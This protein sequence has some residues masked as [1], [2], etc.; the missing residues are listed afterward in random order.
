MDARP[1]APLRAR[2]LAVVTSEN[3]V[4]SLPAALF[5]AVAWALAW[6]EGG[7]VDA[8]DWLPYAIF[9]ALLLVAVF[10]SGR[11]VR[12]TRAGLIGV[13]GLLCLAGWTAISLTWSPLPEAAR[14]DALLATLYAL[15]F[16]AALVVGGQGR[17]KATMLGVVVAGFGT[18]ALATE[19][20]L[21]GTAHPADLYASG[22]LF[23][24]I[25]YWNAQAAMFL[26]GFWPAVALAARRSAPLVLRALSCGVAAS[27]LA[28]AVLVQSKGGTIG[29]AISVIAVLALAKDRLRILVVLLLTAV[30]VAAAY[31]P[32][33]RPYR[34][35]T[36]GATDTAL[37]AGIRSAATWAIAIGVG[38]AALGAIYALLDSRLELTA[39]V[40]RACAL[41]ALVGLLL[42][43]L[44]GVSAA[45]VTIDHPIAFVSHKW[46]AFKHMPTSSGGSS[47][48]F[49]LGSNRYDF[50]RVAGDEFVAHPLA[51]IGQHG[52]AAAYLIKGRSAETPQR[53]HSVFLDQLSETGIVGFLF[54]V[55]GIGAPLVLIARRARSSILHAGI[56]GAGIY[57]LVHASVDWIW[58]FPAIGIPLFLLLGIGAAPRTNRPLGLRIGIPAAVAVGFITLFAFVPPWLSD[59]FTND[60]L[61][62]TPATAR[63][64]LR[65]ARR[66]DPLAVDPFVVE[67]EL[68]TTQAGSVAALRRAVD[69]EPRSVT[70]WYQLGLEELDAGRYSHARRDLR[71]ARRLDPRDP[72][73]AAALS[74][75]R[76]KFRQ[77][78]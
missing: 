21:I 41:A 8:A 19:I 62:A 45:L 4:R 48:L 17:S 5:M 2:A 46:Q 11:A 14:N 70:N 32:L 72:L 71:V 30:P 44:G 39:K 55:V 29:L 52:F 36:S 64:D 13:G 27:L 78:R 9:C 35:D 65:W 7:S 28:G 56:F 22:R 25:G 18:L 60:A 37:D 75:V 33:T 43:V 63:D 38:V 1:S 58:A 40:R 23:F 61:S 16:V 6:R 50:W 76:E 67:S 42:A 66:L 10:A 12:P 34:L 77:T 73:I 47:H 68:A 53:A 24:P 51:G 54:L 74:Q 15:V 26:L 31:L 57:W 49:S 59:R 3:L 20:K 69:L